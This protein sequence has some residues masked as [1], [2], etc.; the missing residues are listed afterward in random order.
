[1]FAHS[2]GPW[3][4]VTVGI[5][6]LVARVVRKASRGVGGV[7]YQVLAA[8]L[9]Y[10][11]SAMAYPRTMVQDLEDVFSAPSYLL[12][13]LLELPLAP[14]AALGHSP[15]NALIMGFGLWEA[16]RMTRGIAVTVEGPFR[17]S[18]A[19]PPPPPHASPQQ[20]SS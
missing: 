9:T 5:G 2:Q 15:W 14:I 6:Y 19:S 4:L 13:T 8:V 18:A 3:A 16:W 17:A 11:A 20:T 10:L 1:M 12:H 7:Q